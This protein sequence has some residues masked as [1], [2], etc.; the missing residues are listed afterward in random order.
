MWTKQ[1]FLSKF[2]ASEIYADLK[3]KIDAKK[4]L[5]D[6]IALAKRVQDEHQQLFIVAGI[7]TATNKFIDADYL[8][9]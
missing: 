9:N 3:A 7:V 6:T 2:N 4:L 5:E 8:E 1:V